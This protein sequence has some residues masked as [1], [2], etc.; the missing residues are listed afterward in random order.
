[1][2][3]T[4]RNITLGILASGVLLSLGAARSGAQPVWQETGE[5]SQVKRI[6][7]EKAPRVEVKKA[8]CVF[9]ASSR[10][11]GMLGVQLTNL[12]RELRAHF[13]APEDAGVMVSGVTAESPADKAGIKVGDIITAIDGHKVSSS[14]GVARRIRRKERGEVAEIEVHRDGSSLTLSATIEERERSEVDLGDFFMEDCDELEFDFDFDEEAVKEAIENATRHFRSPEWKS[15]WEWIERFSE[16]E[17]EEKL[18][19]FEK[20]LQKMEKELEALEKKKRE[21]I[22]QY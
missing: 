1:M 8:P 9:I 11:R 3:K 4:L 6:R 14:S 10:R 13:G 12:T 19:E 20:K 5:E 17:L 18:K 22:E 15:Q 21:K 2:T 16:E 7:V